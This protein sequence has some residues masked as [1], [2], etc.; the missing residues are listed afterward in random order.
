MRM[1]DEL[2]CYALLE[3]ANFP[4]SIRLN[5]EGIARN[6]DPNREIT[7]AGLEGALLRMKTEETASVKPEIESLSVQVRFS[8]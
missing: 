3:A 4:T 6:V 5:V 8:P 2:Y 7:V 1:N